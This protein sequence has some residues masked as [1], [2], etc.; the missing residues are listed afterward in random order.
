MDY[1]TNNI[2]FEDILDHYMRNWKNQPSLRIWDK[3]P[4]QKLPES[5]RVLEFAPNTARDMWTYATCC[6]SQIDDIAPLEV[7]MFSSKQDVGLVEL[8]TALA[9]YHRNTTN[10]NLHHTVDFG[11]PWQ[12]DS[13]CSYGF[14]SLPYLDG[15]DLENLSIRRKKIKFYWL[16]PVTESEVYFKAKYGVEALEDKFDNI[17]LNYI[18]PS[19][20]PLI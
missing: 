12:D 19:R 3:G 16:I 6:M 9:Y 5:F 14:V 11:R 1:R 2:Y 8:L 13:L 4:I 15:P 10:V 7:H 17:G 20:L 18:N